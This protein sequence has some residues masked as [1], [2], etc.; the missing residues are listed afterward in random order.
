MHARTG[1]RAASQ[2]DIALTSFNLLSS[3]ERDIKKSSFIIIVTS[4]HEE[5]RLNAWETD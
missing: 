3:E 2:T 5:N 4:M 1:V